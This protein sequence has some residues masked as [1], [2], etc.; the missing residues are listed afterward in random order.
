MDAPDSEAKRIIFVAIANK[1]IA[2]SKWTCTNHNVIRIRRSDL[3]NWA[4]M[5]YVIY[6]LERLTVRL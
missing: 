5:N 6:K 2:K 1:H 4:Y 3:G